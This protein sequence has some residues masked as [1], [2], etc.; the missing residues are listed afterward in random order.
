M[1]C[2]LSS[3]KQGKLIRMTAQ[4]YPESTEC[5]E[6]RTAIWP[7]KNWLG[8]YENTAAGSAGANES[9]PMIGGRLPGLRDQTN[10][11]S[12]LESGM[13]GRSLTFAPCIVDL[14]RRT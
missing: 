13:G 7:E 14:D 11:R 1:R 9:P 5:P 12:T 4:T 10:S 2:L 6:T 8:P 3:T